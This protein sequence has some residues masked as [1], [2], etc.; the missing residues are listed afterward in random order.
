MIKPD[1]YEKMGRLTPEQKDERYYLEKDDLY[2]VG[3]AEH[4]LG[5]LQMDEVLNNK[6][7]PKR[8]VGFSS[9]FRREAGSYGKDTTGILRVHQFDKVEMY[10]LTKPEMS[11]EEHK[12][13]LS[14]EEKIYKELEIPYQV[15][16]ICTGDMDMVD[17]RQFEIETWIPTQNKYRE[18]ASCSNTTTYQTRGINAKYNTEKGEKELLHALN[19]TAIAMSRTIV[20]ILENNQMED[21]SIK[22]PKK[23]QKYTSFK[24]IKAEK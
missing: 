5:P 4:T 2:L 19:A 11:E 7:I 23:L 6:E 14:M 24:K 10:S 16:E 3:S 21:G 17:A 13:L 22:I 8:Y 18:V 9:C 12:F 1:V 15:V 20:A